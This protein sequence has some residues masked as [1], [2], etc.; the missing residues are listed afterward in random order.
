MIRPALFFR[1]N[2]GERRC[3]G[4]A[5]RIPRSAIA[6]KEVGGRK[7]MERIVSGFPRGM[8]VR[9]CGFTEN[10]LGSLRMRA[11]FRQDADRPSPH[12]DRGFPRD[13]LKAVPESESDRLLRA[14]LSSRSGCGPQERRPLTN[15]VDS[16]FCG[17]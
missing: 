3:G 17:D 11:T 2:P 9:L 10:R 1:F 4:S 14:L 16:H 15:S 8:A 13:C 5:A 12:A 7:L 6:E